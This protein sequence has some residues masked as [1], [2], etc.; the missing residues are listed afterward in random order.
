MFNYMVRVADGLGIELNE[1]RGWE[2]KVDKLSFKSDTTA[3]SF[4]DIAAVPSET[5]ST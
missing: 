1:G 3:K 5:V 2:T 4:G